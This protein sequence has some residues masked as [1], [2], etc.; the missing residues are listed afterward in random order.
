MELITQAFS[1]TVVYTLTIN[2][3]LLLTGGISIFL[4]IKRK[5]NK[6]FIESLSNNIESFRKEYSEVIEL[7]EILNYELQN[8]KKAYS[9][10]LEIMKQENDRFYRQ[11]DIN[12]SA[13]HL[14]S[15]YKTLLL[16][17]RLITGVFSGIKRKIKKEL[18]SEDYSELLTPS[19]FLIRHFEIDIPGFYRT[20]YRA[21]KHEESLVNLN[22]SFETIV[23]EKLFIDTYS[24]IEVHLQNVLRSIL[25]ALPGYIKKDFLKV[26]FE[27][28]YSSKSIS[29]LRKIII[30]DEIYEIFH[31]GNIVDIIRAIY[32][33]L[34]ISKD[35]IDQLPTKK[36][37]L[38][39]KI[40]NSLVHSDGIINKHIIN[41]LEILRIDHNLTLDQNIR[42]D[43]Y[44]YIFDF[45]DVSRETMDRFFKTIHNNIE[46]MAKYNAANTKP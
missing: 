22:T 34:D 1:D 2:I 15:L 17:T 13:I 25:L 3:I 45:S 38:Y 41:S 9:T 42:P 16:R 21:K 36:L 33:K 7:N 29:D 4:V 37:L 30:E 23:M 24:N 14:T 32:K 8:T 18:P 43:L 35:S 44:H 39:S 40:R 6:Y 31:A 46:R 26:K 27:H 5:T 12:I 11:L 10:L 20:I 19:L 28:L